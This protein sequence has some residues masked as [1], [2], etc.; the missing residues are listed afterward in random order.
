MAFPWKGGEAVLAEDLNILSTPPEVYVGSPV[1][2][3][4]LTSASFVSFGPTFTVDVPTW[5]S[6]AQITFGVVGWVQ[7]GANTSDVRLAI[8]SDTGR[9]C[10][11]FSNSSPVNARVGDAWTDEITLTA[12]GLQTLALQGRRTAGTS[13]LQMTTSTDV[14]F[15]VEWI[16]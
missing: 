12:S 1:G 4:D 8:G 10:A 13:N 3:V 15:R 14:T 7:T 16:R 11:P 5:A 6:K 9:V 2:T